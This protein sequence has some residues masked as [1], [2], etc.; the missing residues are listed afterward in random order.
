M[1]LCLTVLFIKKQAKDGSTP[2][3]HSAVVTVS[4][5]NRLTWSYNYVYRSSQ[6][7]ALSSNTLGDLYNVLLCPTKELPDESTVDELLVGYGSGP[8]KHPSGYVVVIEG[9][10]Y[11]DGL[12]END[13]ARYVFLSFKAN[14]NRWLSSKLVAHTSKPVTIG[15]KTHEMPFS[16]LSLRLNNP[17]WLVHHGNCEHFLVVDQIRYVSLLP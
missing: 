9:T 4:V 12:T 6:H 16:S 15:S 11:G 8:S 13:Y 17:Y 2:D 5:Y 10:A 3:P 7:V 14:H 1:P